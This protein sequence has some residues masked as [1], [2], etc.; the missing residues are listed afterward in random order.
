[1][2]AFV[3]PRRDRALPVLILGIAALAF[4]DVGTFAFLVPVAAAGGVLAVQPASQRVQRDTATW[5]LVTAVGAAAFAV[6]RLATATS[7]PRVT[8]FAIVASVVAAG[9]EEVVFRRGLYALLERWGP[10]VAIA[11]TSMVFALVHVPMYGWTVI[12]LD[13][14][15]G[16]VLGWQRWASGTWTAPAVAHAVANVLGSL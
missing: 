1:M 15:A 7:A 12:P 2:T 10:V 16:V 4:R 9:A 6:A 14:A 3:V 13:T 8:A 5:L 11:S